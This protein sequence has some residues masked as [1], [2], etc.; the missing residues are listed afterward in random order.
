MPH[1]WRQMWLVVF[2]DLPVIEPADRKAATK[3]HGFLVD[4]GFERL[5]YSVYMRYCGSAEKVEAAERRVERSL[6]RH[7]NVV[8]L[9]LTD[10]QMAGMKRWIGDMPDGPIDPPPQ[11]RLF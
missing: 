8:A 5:H 11:Y 7:G 1:G 3:F 6:P 4:E 9:R 2:Y 10:R